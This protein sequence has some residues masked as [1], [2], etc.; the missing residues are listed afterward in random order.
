MPSLPLFARAHEPRRFPICWEPR[1][2][3]AKKLLAGH[4]A[5]HRATSQKSFRRPR[6]RVC[7]RCAPSIGDWPTWR[8]FE[9]RI[10][11]KDEKSSV[12]W[13]FSPRNSAF[14]D[15]RVIV[16]D[17]VKRN[18]AVRPIEPHGTCSP[19]SV[20]AK[21]VSSEVLYGSSASVIVMT[22]AKSSLGGD[23]A[24]MLHPPRSRAAIIAQRQEVTPSG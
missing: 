20:V 1:F 8:S 6:V 7:S 21:L 12:R 24:L 2:S 15:S 19:A 13:P 17:G 23:C 10:N 11:A 3:H 16:T 18:Q 14:I 5:Q 4:Y 9:G 22:L